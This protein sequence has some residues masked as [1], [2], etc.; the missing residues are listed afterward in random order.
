M[1]MIKLD[2]SGVK[3]FVDSNI[4]SELAQKSKLYNQQ[5]HDGTAAGNDFLGWVTLPNEIGESE[6]ARIE[7][8]SLELSVIMLLVLVLE[9][10]TLAFALFKKH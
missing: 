3:N 8:Q 5:L 6:F 7:Q 10:A 2:L 4:V 9:V 1:E